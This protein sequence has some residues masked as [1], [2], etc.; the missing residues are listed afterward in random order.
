MIQSCKHKTLWQLLKWA[1]QSTNEE[2]GCSTNTTKNTGSSYSITFSPV[3]VD[4]QTS[5]P[6]SVQCGSSGIK[7]WGTHEANQIK[8]KPSYTTHALA[9]SPGSFP[10]SARGKSL[11]TRLLM[12]YNPTKI[13]VLV[14]RSH[15]HLSGNEAGFTV[16][17]KTEQSQKTSLSCKMS[18]LG[19]SFPETR[20]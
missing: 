14:P 20:H 18:N 16:P 7:Q 11:G 9:S 6:P 15:P 2:H 13:D 3:L 8:T 12:H 5:H 17:L 1:T 10:L 19:M 4:H